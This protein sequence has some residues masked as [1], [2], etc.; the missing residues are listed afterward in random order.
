MLLG[1]QCCDRKPS[2]PPLEVQLRHVERTAQGSP[3]RAVQIVRDAAAEVCAP[4][5][6]EQ[7]HVACVALA[8]LG[9]RRGLAVASL[10]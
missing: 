4:L 8:E 2:P 1:Q 7:E 5:L 10:S 9:E 6:D 3:A